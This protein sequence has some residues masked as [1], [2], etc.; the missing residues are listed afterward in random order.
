VKGS[1]CGNNFRHRATC[2]LLSVSCPQAPP[3]PPAPQPNVSAGL[4]NAMANAG[5]ATKADINSIT[6]LIT[7]MSNTLTTLVTNVTLHQSIDRHNDRARRWN[8]S[9]WRL[10]CALSQS[11][12]LQALQAENPINL[13][14]A[15]GLMPNGP[16]P[17]TV[18]DCTNLQP[19]QLA[20]LEAFYQVCLTQFCSKDARNVQ[21]SLMEELSVFSHSN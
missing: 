10:L 8:A 17:A 4:V 3:P 9:Q 12:P 15:P 7:N 20:T 2:V 1:H 11:K 13:S 21:R 19:Q 5:L 16:F 6:N 14:Q 18:Q